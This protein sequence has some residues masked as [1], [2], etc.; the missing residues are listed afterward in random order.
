MS[1]D[2]VAKALDEWIAAQQNA[3][4]KAGE[5]A[6]AVADRYKVDLETVA[7]DDVIA[8]AEGLQNGTFYLMG[9]S[10]VLEKALDVVAAVM[11]DPDAAK[12]ISKDAVS[13]FFDNCC[14]LL[15]VLENAITHHAT[16]LDHEDGL[17]EKE[18]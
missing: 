14:K 18:T 13:P 7:L 11:L 10:S 17:D 6:K 5:F 8:E 15:T 12:D 3:N 9:V 4:A 1:M 16:G 2:E